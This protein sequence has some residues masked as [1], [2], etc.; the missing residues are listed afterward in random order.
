MLEE[1]RH[2]CTFK[3]MPKPSVEKSLQVFSSSGIYSSSDL[4]R[5][6]LDM[7]DELG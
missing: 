3:R 2:G 1:G 5:R 6:V 7:E 4:V